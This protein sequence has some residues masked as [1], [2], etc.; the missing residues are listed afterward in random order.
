MATVPTPVTVAEQFAKPVPR[1]A[2]VTRAVLK[3][4]VKVAVIV[5]PACRAPVEL[6]VNGS[7]QDARAPTERVLAA[8]WPAV[9]VVATAITTG[10]PGLTEV[11]SADV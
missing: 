8:A 11:V 9:G 4:A 7:T 10:E 3:P 2:V 1:V 6:V 5:S